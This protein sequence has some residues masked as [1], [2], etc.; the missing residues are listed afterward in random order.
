[1]RDV[2]DCI[3]CLKLSQIERTK[4]RASCTLTDKVSKI[5]SERTSVCPR[6]GTFFVPAADWRAKFSRPLNLGRDTPL[7]SFFLFRC[8]LL[9]SFHSIPTLPSSTLWHTKQALTRGA[10]SNFVA[11]FSCSTRR[12]VRYLMKV[13]WRK[14]K[15]RNYI[16]LFG[17]VP[18][19]RF[20][21]TK[22]LDFVRSPL[23]R[24]ITYLCRKKWQSF[25][26]DINRW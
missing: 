4:L 2:R 23:R 13:W 19:P 6:T 16:V 5:Y 8:C 7:L 11:S 24:R 22:W 3:L 12:I 9:L 26:H 10:L 18:V 17:G 25:C 1:M 15:L 14:Q 20:R 21:A